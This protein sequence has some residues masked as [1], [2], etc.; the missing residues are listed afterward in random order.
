VP[1]S[2]YHLEPSSL[3]GQENLGQLLFEATDILK[4]KKI[5]SNSKLK[6][7]EL[8]CLPF[9]NKSFTYYSFPSV[10]M[11]CTGGSGYGE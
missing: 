5:Y 1:P 9:A 11:K 3:R 4:F 10:Y 8:K 6:K 7:L 2:K